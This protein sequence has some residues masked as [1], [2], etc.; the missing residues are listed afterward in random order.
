[1]V[2]NGEASARLGGLTAESERRKPSLAARSEVTGLLKIR[3]VEINGQPLRV[4]ERR[5]REGQPPLL[6]FNGVGANL[7]LVE[8]FVAALHEVIPVVT[9]DIPGVGGSPSPKLPYRLSGVAR[10]GRE[11][12]PRLGYD[13]TFDVLGVSWGGAVAQQ[14]ARSYPARCRRLVLAATSPGAIMVP[15]KLSALA[16]LASPRRYLDA[17][18]LRRVGADLYGGT[19]RKNPERLEELARHI[20]PPGGRGY[21]YQLIA[22][23]GWTSLPWLHRIRH[24]TLILHGTDDPIV[25]LTNAKIL[26]AL[27]RG[28]R[29]YVVDDGHLFLVSRAREIG[30]V[31]S[32]FLTEPFS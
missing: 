17:D 18:Y 12:M 16:K 13:W 26:A 1:L 32:K 2:R 20:M 28:S 29:L 19:Y 9:F 31:V 11:L 10:L 25:P 24:P 6:L 4:G 7:E 5:G 23:A 3:T 27:I 8:P 21:A 30:P 14:F 15:G 22:G